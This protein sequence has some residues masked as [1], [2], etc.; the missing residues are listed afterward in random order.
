MEIEV[1]K[2]YRH[3][4]GKTYTILTIARH[5]DT[6]EKMVV[7]QAEYD[8]EELGPRPVF[9]RPYDV[10]TEHVLVDGELVER[11]TKLEE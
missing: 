3:Y 4:K 9:V 7:Y 10:F 11:F 8:D 6:L 1:G 5:S 2:R